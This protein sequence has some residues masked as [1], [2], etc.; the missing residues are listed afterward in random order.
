MHRV[1]VWGVEAMGVRMCG[2][3][4]MRDAICRGVVVYWDGGGF[5]I[6]CER[7]IKRHYKIG[8]CWLVVYLLYECT[9]SKADHAGSEASWGVGNWRSL[10][11]VISIV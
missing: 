11:P 2:G 7:L 4:R 6:I 8:M 9:V 5:I 3:W 10:R 1:D